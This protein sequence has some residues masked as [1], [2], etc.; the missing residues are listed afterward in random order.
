MNLDLRGALM[1][2]V[3]R[4]MRILLIVISFFSLSA[5]GGEG[6]RLPD[7]DKERLYHINHTLTANALLNA[8]MS[9]DVLQRRLAEAYALGALSATQGIVWCNSGVLSPD[10]FREQIYSALKQHQG[11]LASI[12]LVN[13][14]ASFSPCSG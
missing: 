2:R 3:F 7:N 5:L 11:D 8:Y 13:H 14:F 6:I 10:A 12:V 9:E 4:L 1:Y